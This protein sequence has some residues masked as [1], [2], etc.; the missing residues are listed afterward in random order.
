MRMAYLQ[1]MIDNTEIVRIAEQAATANLTS[2][3]VHRVMSEP[4]IDSQ[5]D[6]ALRITIVIAP[7]SVEGITGD[8]ALKTLVDIQHGLEA[9]GES[10]FAVVDYAAENERL[11]AGN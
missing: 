2:Q 7:N 1:P 5:G 11:N 4:I 3:V 6:D 8:A 9:A 10:R